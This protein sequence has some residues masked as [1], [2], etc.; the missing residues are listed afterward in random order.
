MDSNIILFLSFAIIAIAIISLIPKRFRLPFLGI[1]NCVFYLLCSWKMFGILVLVAL[2]TWLVGNTLCR[3]KAKRK[4]WLLIGVIP[5]ILLLFLTKYI[6]ILEELFAVLIHLIV[7]KVYSQNLLQAITILGLSYYA[8]RSISYLIDVYKGKIVLCNDLT[9][10]PNGSEAIPKNVAC[11]GFITLFTYISF[12]PHIVCGPIE[13]YERFNLS[14][15]NLGFKE[16]IFVEGFKKIVWG[17]FMKA[18]IADNL[19]PFVNNVFEDYAITPSVALWAGAFF[20]TI[21]LYCDFAGYSYIAIG[22]TNMMGMDCIKNFDRPY[23]SRSIK[24]FWNRWHISLSIWLRDYVY[25]PLGGSRCSKRRKFLNVM[26]TFLVSGMWHGAGLSFIVWG[27][28]HG[29]FVYLSPKS[30]SASTNSVV[31]GAA[32]IST[33]FIA[34]ML[35]IFFRADSLASALTY[36]G[37]MFTDFSLSVPDLQKTLLL[38]H[39]DN[40][41]IA[42]FTT[43]CIFIAIFAFKEWNDEFKKIRSR[44]WLSYA[45]YSFLIC[46]IFLFGKFGTGFIYGN[47]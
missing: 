6:G 12:F 29:L 20:Y 42:F 17:L 37:R 45:W 19:S 36:I 41:S 39:S 1:T 32:T 25:F 14:I 26:I 43:V 38:F 8:F 11:N 23:F 21:Q 40:T 10:S 15:P 33:F 35:W 31:N 4:M 28:L 34:C 3:K 46:S 16:S 7:G 24:E 27:L 13:R 9:P 2:I 44:A 47:F 5:I 22:V 30:I 18:V